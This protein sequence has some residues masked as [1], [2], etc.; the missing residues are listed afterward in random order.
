MIKEKSQSSNTKNIWNR[1]PNI[2]EKESEDY[3]NMVA[4]SAVAGINKKKA[5]TS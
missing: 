2:N 5:V 3:G 1:I 4:D